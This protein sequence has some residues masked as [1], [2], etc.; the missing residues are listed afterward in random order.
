MIEKIICVMV[1][2]MSLVGLS[3]ATPP[4]VPSFQNDFASKMTNPNGDNK[5]HTTERVYNLQI[6]P[7]KSLEENIRNLFYP[8]AAGG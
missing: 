5:E 3:H 1:M 6:D 7:N 8:S 2:V 4:R